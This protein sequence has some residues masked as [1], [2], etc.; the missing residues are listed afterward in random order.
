MTDEYIK[1]MNREQ[2]LIFDSGA[3]QNRILIF[4]TENNLKLMG[5][6]TT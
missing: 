6:L 2:F 4:S 3:S 1:T 5:Q